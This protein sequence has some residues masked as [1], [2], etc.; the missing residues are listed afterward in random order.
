MVIATWDMSRIGDVRER[1][2]GG[3][4]IH[5]GLARPT[6]EVTESGLYES[7]SRTIRFRLFGGQVLEVLCSGAIEQYI[8]IRSVKTL[9]P[10]SK[11]QPRNPDNEDWI[12][13]KVYKGTSDRETG[14]LTRLRKMSCIWVSQKY[15]CATQSVIVT[16]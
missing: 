9:Q 15:P 4:E 7:Y 14:L 2:E 8:K 12:T 10:V 6:C 16:L 5:G 11:P 13:P 3:I 1:G